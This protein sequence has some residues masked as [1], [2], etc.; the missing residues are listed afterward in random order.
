MVRIAFEGIS[1]DFFV[2]RPFEKRFVLALVLVAVLAAQFWTQS[3]YP[4]LDDKAIMS[5]AIQLEDP[6]SFEAVLP[7]RPA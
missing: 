5:G 1:M 6:L 4:S 3:R 2:I 7:I